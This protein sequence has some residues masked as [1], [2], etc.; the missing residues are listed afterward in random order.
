MTIL[1]DA[2]VL[3]VTRYSR[4]SECIRMPIRGSAIWTTEHGWEPARPMLADDN[5]WSDLC[6]RGD[7]EMGA[8]LMCGD[9][10]P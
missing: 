3:L 6:Y 5:I 7:Y 10:E 4:A 1:R 8:V 2:N 9:S